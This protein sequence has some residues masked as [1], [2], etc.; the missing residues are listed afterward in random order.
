[1]AARARPQGARGARREV[2]ENS[3]MAKP[4]EERDAAYGERMIELHIS[5][6]TNDIVPGKGRIRPKHGWTSGDVRIE[7]NKAHGIPAGT[8]PVIFHS[9]MDLP[10]AIGKV[11]TANGIKL[12]P[13]GRDRKYIDTE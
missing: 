6:W 5:F 2:K 10:A 13:S 1:V 4:I 9:L 8:E 11:L 12:H 3:G 7:K